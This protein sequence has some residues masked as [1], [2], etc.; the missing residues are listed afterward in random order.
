MREANFTVAA[1][2]TANG[3]VST[4]ISYEDAHG[5]STHV[6]P[7]ARNAKWIPP[8]AL[9]TEKFRHVLMVRGWVMAH[10]GKPFNPEVSYERIDAIATVRVLSKY[11]TPIPEYEKNAAAVRR[12]GTYL[13]LQAAIAYRAWRQGQNSVEIAEALGITPVSVR[14]SLARLKRIAR[15][16]GYDVG[17][18]HPTYSG[19][20]T[21][22]YKQIKK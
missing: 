19:K 17:E 21:R 8:F 6:A 9:D 14:Q 15:I 18:S 4:G 22:K 12:A 20:E 16:I 5:M 3:F 1:H 2:A 10:S 11:R 7:Y 13:S